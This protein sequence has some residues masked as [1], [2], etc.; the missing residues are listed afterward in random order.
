MGDGGYCAEAS[1][2]ALQKTPEDGEAA[3]FYAAR[4]C[5]RRSDTSCNNLGVCYERGTGVTKSR[6]KAEQYY[7]QACELGAGL[8]CF[9]LAN[10]LKAEE[11]RADEATAHFDRACKLKWGPGCRAAVTRH[12]SERAVALQRAEEG[13]ELEDAA[14]CGMSALL[15]AA[16]EPGSPKARQRLVQVTA[17]CGREQPGS[18]TTLAVLYAG[19]FG[20]ERDRARSSELLKR[21]CRHGFERACQLEQQPELLE[22]TIALFSRITSTAEP[23]LKVGP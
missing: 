12:P 7:R 4:G 14:S 5:E 8:G 19:G 22:E 15:L 2:E 1:N 23:P 6:A 21:A 10:L 11:G 20:V 18:C 13:C 17:D 16:T 3:A 9:N